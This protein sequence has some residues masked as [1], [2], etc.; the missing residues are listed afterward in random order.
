MCVTPLHPD[1]RAEDGQGMLSVKNVQT[2]SLHGA[3]WSW[4]GWAG[5]QAKGLGA[6]M[7]TLALG[8]PTLGVDLD[9]I[10]VN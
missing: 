9:E 2:V 7:Y 8:L 4:G 6:S 1:S 10:V 5:G 3:G